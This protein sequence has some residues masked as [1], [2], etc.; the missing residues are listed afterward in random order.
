MDI[1]GQNLELLVAQLIEF[2]PSLLAA[3]VVFVI[4]LVVAGLV[5]RALVRALQRRKADPEIT[6]LVSK[7]VRW[8]VL[9]FGLVLALEQVNFNLTAFLA[10]LGILGFTVGFALQDVSKNFIAGLLLLLQQ[11]F[12]LGDTIT[13]AGYTGD[14]KLVDLRATEL[15]MP[16]GLY[17]QIPNADLFT[18]PI[19]NVTRAKERRVA[20]EIGVAYDSDLEEVRRVALNAILTIKGLKDTPAPEVVFHDFGESTIDLTVY[21]W[22]DPRKTTVRRATDEGLAAIKKAFESAGI[23]MPFP[24]Q[25]V[26][27]REGHGE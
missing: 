1:V 22:L 20:L 24:T 9:V 11:P 16:D 3:L 14:V 7:I 17:V 21:Y 2:I 18:S 26:V 25:V 12:D 5:S 15:R 10:G 13:V 19:V 27:R 23:E 4:T 6:L 8:A